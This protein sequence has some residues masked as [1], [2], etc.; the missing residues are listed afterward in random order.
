MFDATFLGISASQFLEF[1]T[2]LFATTAAFV[3]LYL[4]N[5]PLT[6]LPF[7]EEIADYKPPPWLIPWFAGIFLFLLCASASAGLFLRILKAY[8]SSDAFYAQYYRSEW[9]P[10]IPKGLGKLTDAVVT[11]SAEEGNFGIYANG[12]MLFAAE[13]DCGLVFLCKS[14]ADWAANGVSWNGEIA[15]LNNLPGPIATTYYVPGQQH[16]LPY[17]ISI[18]SWLAPGNNFV[19]LHS[20]YA[21]MGN[22]RLSVS[23][24]LRFQGTE[25]TKAISLDGDTCRSGLAKYRTYDAYISHRLCDRIRL[26][27]ALPESAF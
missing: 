25:L 21:G 7:V 27:F 16:G 18:R 14:E 5:I 23:L 22:Y 8:P 13:P 20:S 26:T 6:K 24:K 17:D 4:L 15:A 3:F 10:Q 1:A 9:G 19:D 12:W 11:L 2:A